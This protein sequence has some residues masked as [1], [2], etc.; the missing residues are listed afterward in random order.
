M[1]R[2]KVANLVYKLSGFAVLLLSF[3]GGWLAMDYKH[4]VSTPLPI[5]EPGYHH[6]I[7][8]GTSLKRFSSDLYQA[9]PPRP[10]PRT[11]P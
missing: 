1:A 11:R 7:A 9:G 3:A 6:V 10:P 8:M 4:Y 5:A 2:Q